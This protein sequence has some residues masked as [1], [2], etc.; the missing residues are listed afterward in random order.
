MGTTIVTTETQSLRDPTSYIG[1]DQKYTRNETARSSDSKFWS[2]I[3]WKNVTL[4]LYVHLA[5]I[6]GLYL[7]FT[8]IKGLTT[9]WGEYFN[10]TAIFGIF[11]VRVHVYLCTDIVLCMCIY[12]YVYP[13]C[14]CGIKYFRLCH[15][16]PSSLTVAAR[17]QHQALVLKR[18]T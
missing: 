9:L 5:A 4:F 6:Y 1:T 2:Q 8:K 11:Y 14:A 18:G 3:V 15:F 12:A 16:I 13:V 10:F 17:G 7:I